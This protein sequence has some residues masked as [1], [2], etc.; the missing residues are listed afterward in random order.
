MR[1]L[2][3][4]LFLVSI[5]CKAESKNTVITGRDKAYI[6][7]VVE[8]YKTIDYITNTKEL[9]AVDTIDAQGRFFLKF[10]QSQT[11]LISI[12]LGIYNT[13]LFAEPGKTYEVILPPYQPKTKADI[14]NP[15]FK[16]VEMYL[17]IKNRD[18]LDINYRIADFNDTYN[19]YLDSHPNI[20]YKRTNSSIVDSSINE[21]EKKYIEDESLFFKNYRKY[22]YAFLKFTTYMK[23]YRYVVREYY[24]NNKFLY[25][26]PA[27]MNLFNQIFAN[28]LSVYMETKE[29]ERI[30]S[31]IA[32]AKSPLFAKETFANNMVLLNDTLSELVLLKGLH[33]AFSSRNFPL[34]SLIITLDSVSCCSN[35]EYHKQISRDIKQKVLQARQGFEAPKFELVDRYG[36]LINS[37]SLF[38]SFVYL[39]F[40]SIESFTCLQ[41]FELL[42]KMYSEHK[43]DFNI[44]SICI[45]D[46][47]ETTKKFFS[48]KGYDWELL[49]YKKQ[50]K[51][52]DD[53]KVR[54][55]P[56]YYLINPEK[57]LSLSPAVSPG[58]NFEWSFFKIKKQY[59]KYHGTIQ[60]R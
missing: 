43:N 38:K 56:S 11:L 7:S 21:M 46:D 44:V 57:K 8:V 9:L 34:S 23:D 6:G 32:Y 14:L 50:K 49:S 36:K 1:Y 24:H 27:Y 54:V 25:Q 58:E 53:Y 10:T 4:I 22:R 60:E 39:S 47:F 17:G 48:E 16:P 37:D 55:Y 51:V 33:D 40:V 20:I 28:Y 15:F 13:V 29:G 41:D 12:P 59:D 3:V 45:D 30:Y 42:K 35:V 18:S 52:I 2:I 26:N 19:K 5:Y 31:D